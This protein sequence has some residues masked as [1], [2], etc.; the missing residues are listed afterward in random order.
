MGD[1]T[2]LV[3]LD[4]QM[5]KMKEYV[6]N[7]FKS[8]FHK[9]YSTI[10][11][12]KENVYICFKFYTIKIANT[13]FVK[14]SMF[15]VHQSSKVTFRYKKNAINGEVHRATKIASSFQSETA[16]IKAKFLKAVFPSKVI[17]N[18]FNN[19]NN[20]GEELIIQRWFF[21]ERKIVVI[22]VPF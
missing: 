1:L 12:L 6:V 17:E 3:L 22:N 8:V 5:C 20:V 9:R 16:R 10:C 15:L 11:M 21:Y 18:I 19:S 2:L 7:C 4:I 14:K 13:F